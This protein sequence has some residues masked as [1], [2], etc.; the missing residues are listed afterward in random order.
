MKW[1]RLVHL[2]RRDPASIA[3]DVDDELAFHLRSR[4]DD[5]VAQ[6]ISPDDARRR[7]REEFGDVDEARRYATALD[8]DTATIH[9]RRDFMDELRQDVLYAL[10]RL[11]RAPAFTLTAMATLALGIGATAAI[12][13]LVNAV[14]LRPLPFR[15]PEQLVR[16]WS[17]NRGSGSLRATV[18]AVDLDDW[19]SQR[20]VIEDVGGY[21]Y[22]SGATGLDLT[23]DGEPQ[24][25]TA[26]FVT[27]GFFPAL[28]VTAAL[29]R[30]PREDE[31]VRGGPD[32]VVM[33]THAFWQ[34]QYQG[35]ADIVGSL[36]RLR[37]EPYTV[38]GVLPPSM[39]WPAATADIYAPFSIFTDEDIPR[40]RVVR[41][42]SVVARLRPGVTLAG[43]SAEMQTITR[44]LAERYPENRSWDGATVMPLRES[45][46]G[47]VRMSLLVLL[48]AVGV[49]LLIACANVASLQ[50][51]RASAR[52]GEVAVRAAL[53]ATRGR[54]VRHLLTESLVLGLVGGVAGIGVTLLTLRAIDTVAGGQ[55]PREMDVSV[56]GPVLLFTVLTSIVAGVLAG[57]VPAWQG[58]RDLQPA[59]RGGRASGGAATLRAR[60]VLV[61][62]EV[63]MA[64][65]LVVGGGLMIRTFR[66]LQQVDLGL[67]P[68]HLLNVRFT[69]STDRHGDRYTQVYSQMLER[70]RAL[71]G[72]VAAG[73]ISDSPLRDAGESVSFTTPGMVLPAGEDQPSAQ[74]ARVSDGIFRALGARLINGRE[75]AP[76]DRADAPLVVVV[77]AALAKRWFPGQDAVGQRLLLGGQAPAEII[78]VVAD[79]RQQDVGRDPPETVYL[80]QQ[81]NG[82]VRTNLMVRTVGDPMA[83]APLV[84]DAIREVDPLQSI[85]GVATMESTVRDALSRPRLLTSLL[86]A[87]GAIAL[88]LGA[89]GLYGVLS[90]LVQQRRKELGIRMALGASRRELVQ[91]VVRHGLRLAAWG[92]GIGTL[93]ALVGSRVMTS[94]VHGVTATDATTYVTVGMVLLLT[95]GIASWLPARRA[96]G[97]DVVG[98]LRN[99]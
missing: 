77:N 87:Y 56:D 99:D 82:R 55:L 16:V 59:L 20:E 53:G 50:L 52:A 98:A 47:D 38:I 84:R 14:L 89:L 25:L 62:A 46:T 34:R 41:V 74:S 58:A 23:G 12:F 33:L 76:S 2:P 42:L 22:S 5:L 13:S 78:G 15:Q 1:R 11:R 73:A 26:V 75:F 24:R 49:L 66:S 83:M 18:S 7:A 60:H 44:R 97:V 88:L 43:A 80:S 65:M 94:V 4:E 70:V 32:R 81:Q 9:R 36:I 35:R 45:V 6:G 51:S 17:A 37:G 92:V 68:D 28:G 85:T 69:L 8:T 29:G 3:R 57:V 90:Y 71:P 61:I 21:L 31:L 91:M 95:A 96:A 27:P 54:L 39:T 40:L 79:L 86:G 30:L 93:L 19:R 63:A 48:A 64:M 10:R 72:V 67:V